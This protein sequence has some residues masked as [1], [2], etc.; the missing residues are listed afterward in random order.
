MRKVFKT[1]TAS[2]LLLGAVSIAHAADVIDEVPLAPEAQD[3]GEAPTGWDG[4]YLGG[5]ITQQ[6]GKVREGGDYNTNGLGAGLYGGY[7]L[8]NG[9]IVYGAETDLNYSGIDSTNNGVKVKQHLNG[10]VR[11]RIGYDLDPV[12]VY[13][14]AGIAATDLKASDSTSSDSNTLI[15]LALGAGVE[16]KI[17]DQITARTEYRFNNYQTQNFKLDSGTVERSLKEHSVNVG[18]G[19]RF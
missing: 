8:Q 11:G 4:A 3:L 14:T 7:N 9:K 13:G 19:V 2:A 16:T 6:W 17:T 12:L 15:G 5:K 1:I 18:L 10:S